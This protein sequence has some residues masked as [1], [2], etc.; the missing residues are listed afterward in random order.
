MKFES[1]YSVYFLGIGGIGM[2]SLASYFHILGKNVAGYDL[3]PSA[4]TDD[5]QKSGIKIH[6]NEDPDQISQEFQDK[7]HSL[8]V[9]TPAVPQDHK[10][11]EYFVE[12]NFTIKKR[13]EVLGILFNVKKGIAI[14]GTHGKT[15]VTSMCAFILHNSKLKCSAFLGGIVKN[16]SSNLIIQEN[17]LWM[18]A[19]AD[20]YDRSFLQL[21]PEIA[22]IT[23]VDADH[24]DI[25][26]SI[27]DIK[28]TFE[29]FLSQVNNGGK[30]IL[31]DGIDLK[32]N[33]EIVTS[34]TY[35]FDNPKSDFYAKNIRCKMGRYSFEIATPGSD[36][37]DITLQYRGLTNIE[38]A[39]AAASIA[40]LAG[41][42]TPVIA[43]S[44]SAFE[45]V[46]RRFDVQYEDEKNIYIDDYAHH[47]RELDAIIGSVRK[48]YPGKRITGVFQPHLYSRTRD[49]A[50]EFAVSLSALDELILL[51]IYPAREKPIAG[52]SS[53]SIFD[54]VTIQ[55]KTLCS[56]NDL[57]EILKIRKPE[58]LLTM[59]AGDIDRYVDDI[60]IMFETK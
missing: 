14:A 6:F 12:H 43:A 39:V 35:S 8:V 54:K 21:K 3:S 32:F 18:V 20:E 9:Y 34:Y 23:W 41:V 56:K 4:I 51:D 53:K 46:R 26:S 40:Y 27:K 30:I 11:L 58:I 19:E 44:L 45:G 10:E 15:S 36:I 55:A 29:K 49:F 47:P 42:D 13:A 22:L 59:G 48:L 24:L 37:Q 16:I 31:K 5:L 7:E 33:D 1:I 52:I 25:Y 17:S 28:E 2:S 57:L 38:N 50:D 60:R